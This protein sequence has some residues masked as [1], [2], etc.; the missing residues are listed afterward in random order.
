MPTAVLFVQS[1]AIDYVVH[2]LD[3][4]RAAAVLKALK[5]TAAYSAPLLDR[6]LA[7]PALAALVP[8]VF[9][10]SFDLFPVEALQRCI[11]SGDI[12][13]DSLLYRLAATANPMHRAVHEE[14]L[15]RALDGSPKW[16]DLRYVANMLRA[17][18]REEVLHIIDAAPHGR[19]DCWFWF[20]RLLE[21]ARGER[22]IN[23]DGAIRH[24]QPKKLP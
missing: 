8:Q 19:E 2:H 13:Q 6:M 7:V 17:Y 5:G 10:D 24:Y 23:E 15:A 11:G 12:D 14:L 9:A 18:S 4:E 20:V 22:L 16:H 21:A 1:L 3:D